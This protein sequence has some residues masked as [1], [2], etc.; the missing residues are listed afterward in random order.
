MNTHQY[1]SQED[2]CEEKRVKRLTREESQ[3]ETRARLVAAAGKLFVRDGYASTSLDRIAEEAGF[4]KGA[5]YSNFANKGEIFLA[6]VEA[7]GQANVPPVLSAISAS[8][9]LAE[10]IEAIASW[11]DKSSQEGN[12]PLLILE[13]ARHEKRGKSFSET[14]E[15]ILRANWRRL[16]ETL[17]ARFPRPDIEPELLGSLVF[18]L[19][20]APAMTFV[21]RPMSGKLVRLALSA[22][23]A[24][25]HDD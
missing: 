7:H 21:A 10:A 1:P 12:W 2:A 24:D 4:S 9:N 20:Y 18:Q 17:L 23:L 8:R 11:A 22:I 25:G 19:T 16:G 13:H 14:Q 5:V 6:V 3:A 15:A